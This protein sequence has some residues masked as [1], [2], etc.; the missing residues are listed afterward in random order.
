MNDQENY[1]LSKRCSPWTCYI[2][3]SQYDKALADQIRRN[4]SFH[5]S[6]HKY[7]LIVESIALMLTKDSIS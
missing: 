7:K 6:A 5:G 1:K 2:K 3:A 4:Y